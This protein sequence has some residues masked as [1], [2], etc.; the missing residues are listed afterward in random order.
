MKTIIRNFISVLRR[1]KLATLL[2]I[3]GLSVAFA[4]F[5]IILMQV[6]YDR[7]FN[8][9]HPGADRIFRMEMSGMMGHE[10]M[11]VVC[12]PYMDLFAASS[13]HIQASTLVAMMG[14]VFFAVEDGGE[15]HRFHEKVE[16]VTSGFT[17]VFT[18]DMVEGS[19]RALS[20]PEKALIPLSLARKLF[21]SQ[22]ATGRQLTDMEGADGMTSCTVGGVYRD[23]PRNSSVTNAVYLPI[24]DSENRQ[25]WGNWNYI[26][27]LRMDRPE[28]T[29]GLFEQFM[30][31]FDTSGL[32][33]YFQEKF[34]HIQARFTPLTELH[35][36][37]GV[38][39]DPTPKTSRQTVFILLCIAIVIVLIAGINYMNFSAALVPKRIKSVNIQKVLGGSSRSIR[40]ALLVEALFIAALSGLLAIGLVISVRNTPVAQFTDADLALSA[41]PALIALLAAVALLT[42][43][44]AGIGPARYLT[45]FRPAIVLKGSFGLSAQGRKLRNTLV[46]IQF[47]AAFALI[48]G[49]AFM[50]LQNHFM[51]HSDLG[52]KRDQ[53]IVTDINGQIN[54]NRDAFVD[55]IQRFA[56]VD[57]VAFAEFLLA[58]G[59]VFMGWGRKFNDRKIQY[60]CLPADP[61]FPEI[62]GIGVTEGRNFREDD[63]RSRHGVYLFNEIA[64]KTFDMKLGDRIDSTE[65]VGFVPDLHFASMR[66]EISPM[67]FLVWGINNWGDQFGFA[68]I[69]V[70]AG[71]DLRAAM[72]HVR[73]VLGEL[74]ASYPFDV[75]FF[76]DVLQKT[77]ES[78]Q[79]M[80]MLIAVFS[81][82]AVFISI[83]GVFGLV[84]FDSE[85]RRRE[86]GI[87]KVFGSTTREI[88][89]AFNRSYVRIL[90]ICFLPAAA[91]GWYAVTR[92]L[93]NFATHTPMYWWVYLMAFTIVFLLTVATVT[94]QNW[95]AASANPVDSIKAE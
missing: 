74:D 76:D 28:H 95:R 46:G 18:F 16:R 53:V 66:R 93:E 14:K 45:S 34:G 82:I 36:V 85:Y 6:D 40:L 60:D 88:L 42:G 25:H 30:Q 20:E 77:Y 64:R 58:G 89:L 49:A 52:F 87:R 21:G 12:R 41:H 11:D 8:R 75:R 55:R 24:P 31:T 84:V 38:H 29:E 15:T 86:I 92:W 61:S 47:T 13:P 56:G 65:I 83:V 72:T 70:K 50:F 59:D 23:F 94:F 67:A 73:D 79:R 33:T 32:D 10:W 62:M 26:A 91:T 9:S 19:D 69:R 39:P 54:K 2:N 43:L 71:S 3:L 1:Y 35:Y 57:G 80:G 4:A 37:T 68:Y 44:L 78:E 7:N 5:L 27:Y 48:I 90:C 17:D 51:Q 81:L 22:P 63:A